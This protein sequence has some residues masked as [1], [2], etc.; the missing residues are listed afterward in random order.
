[1][2]SVLQFHHITT[3]HQQRNAIGLILKMRRCRQR[4]PNRKTS[5]HDLGTSN[6]NDPIVIDKR[7]GGEDKEKASDLL[8]IEIK[9]EKVA[10]Y[11]NYLYLC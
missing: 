10:Q 3:R 2:Q 8:S 4:D 7:F 5:R 1:M 6:V 11:Y 9:E